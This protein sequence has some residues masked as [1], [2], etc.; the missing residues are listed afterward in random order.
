MNA[1][2]LGEA[3]TRL[4][5]LSPCVDSLVA[6]TRCPA[7]DAWAR[8]RLDP[9]AVL[10]VLREAPAARA[11]SSLSCFPSLVHDPAVL[12]GAGR[13]LDGG[14]PGFVNWGLPPAKAVYQS[15]ILYAGAAHWL[16]ER[17]GCADPDNAWV[18]GLLAP[19]G[20]LAACAIDL[21]AVGRCLEDPKLPLCA[22]TAQQ[23]V[24]GL[25]HSA[26][27]RRL[28]RRWRLPGWV[29]AVVGHL[30]LPVQ[31]AQMLGAD[32][33][34]FRIVQAAVVLVQERRNVL[35]L[36]SALPG[37]G[38]AVALD[39]SGGA[40]EDL[41]SQI[42]GWVSADPQAPSWK[43]LRPRRCCVSWWRCPPASGDWRN[44]R[45]SATWKP[46]WTNFIGHWAFSRQARTSA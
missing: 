1:T 26:I 16:A 28:S 23:R 21:D 18:A 20:W 24:W 4:S 45:S 29:A 33:E 46:R 5:W 31:T 27:A 6:L 3:I 41:R 12:E 36:P 13:L 25:D 9:G 8:V 14:G 35:H 10:L 40:I 34:I 37:D 39:L 2:G 17:A 7:V 15:S 11:V 22:H 30:D 19:L 32:P 42:V 44:S 43:A 38:H